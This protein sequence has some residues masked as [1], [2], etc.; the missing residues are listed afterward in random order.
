MPYRGIIADGMGMGKTATA[1]SVLG[2]YKLFPALVVCP[3]SVL[4][5]WQHDEAAMWLPGKTTAHLRLGQAIPRDA[6]I[7][8]VSWDA[9]AGMQSELIARGFKGLILDEVHYAKNPQAQRSQAAFAISQSA[10]SCVSLSGTP[11]VNIKAELEQIHRITAGVDEPIGSPPIIRRLLEDH[12]TDV[13]PKTRVRIPVELSPKY[14]REYNKIESQFKPWL[15]THMQNKLAAVGLDVE[16]DEEVDNRLDRSMKAEHLVRV[17]YLRRL[18]GMAKVDVSVQLTHFLV[19]Q[20]AESVVVFAEHDSV[21]D[22]LARK[23]KRRRINTLRIDG[24]TPKARRHERVRAFQKG[25]APVILASQAAREGVT[26]TRSARMV[27]C[28][29]WWTPAAE[30]QAE[31]RIHRMTQTRRSFIFYPHALGT[32]DERV[33]QIVDVKRKL[34]DEEIGAAIAQQVQRKL[35]KKLSANLLPRRSR[36]RAVLFDRSMFTPERV[37]EW[38]RLNRYGNPDKARRVGSVFVVEVRPKSAFQRGALDTRK[39]AAGV[40]MVVGTPKPRKRKKRSR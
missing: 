21:L 30:E 13:P 39:V 8:V 35:P 27:F 7:C 3:V 38:L 9:I 29:R 32:F 14:K 17:G 18:V 19:S 1:L 25:L 2:R 10:Q 5:N 36:V 31:D 28:E 37:A 40:S 20:Q 23:L 11:L 4:G 33:A 6:A 22:A 15:A 26:L 12:A 16:E 24:S 34:V